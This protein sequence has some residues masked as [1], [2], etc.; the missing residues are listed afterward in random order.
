MK[1]IVLYFNDS[2]VNGS[3]DKEY[4]IQIEHFRKGQWNP[5]PSKEGHVVLFQYGRRGGTLQSGTKTPTPVSL[6]EAERIFDRLV[7]E[8]TSK[9]YQVGQGESVAPTVLTQADSSKRTPYPQEQLE[10]IG[11]DDAEQYIKDDRFI[12]QMKMDGHFRQAEK[13]P[14][15]TVI[16]Y[17][18]KGEAKE[19]PSVVDKELA[20]L[21]LKTFFFDGELIG[22]N[23]FVFQ[24]LQKNG[25]CLTELPYVKRLNH[26]EEI[27]DNNT[28][29]KTVA[30]WFGTKAKQAGLASLRKN[31][32]EG[33]VFKLKDAAYREGSNRKFKFLKTCTA[34]VLELGRKGH[35]NAVLGLLKD[36]KWVEIGGASMIGKDKR[37]T[38]GSL[39]EVKF[40]N[41][42]GS[43]L[44]Q[45]RIERL[46][47]DID[48]KECTFM[49][50]IKKHMF[51]EGVE[52][53]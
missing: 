26:A 1:S 49:R 15:G 30:T 16:S 48:E 23:Y 35:E 31:R 47:D 21:P 28:H 51:K 39:V 13:R 29:I 12:M 34:R 2:A 43:R 53:A 52:A 4:R 5:A 25:K 27:I 19:F 7:H 44:Y 20:A 11:E 32:C 24:M 50:Q 45:P 38:V 9:G 33:A 41:F 36:G 17:N 18:K 40:L 14:D 3:S 10:E 42:T 46:R 22:E 37:I 8:K 6:E